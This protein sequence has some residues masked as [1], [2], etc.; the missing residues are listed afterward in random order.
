MESLGCG[1]DGLA[2]ILQPYGAILAD[3]SEPY[4]EG[5]YVY[6]I[7]EKEAAQLFMSLTLDSELPDLGHWK[8]HIQG[9]VNEVE[10][11]RAMI[12]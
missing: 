8:K 4:S 12:P 6:D 11:H 9:M 2:K 1:Q 10:N 7:C 3:E 5:V